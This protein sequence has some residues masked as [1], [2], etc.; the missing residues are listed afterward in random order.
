MKKMLPTKTKGFTLIEVAVAITIV[1][2]LIGSMAVPLSSRLA[3]QQ[4]TDTQANIDKAMEALMGFALTNQRLPCPDMDTTTPVGV[5]DGL[6]KLNAAGTACN[7]GT[8]TN[9]TAG[10][11]SWGDLPWRTIGLSAPNNADA[12][13]NRLRYAVFEPL[14]SM[15]AAPAIALTAV[16]VGI[17][18]QL[19][20]RCAK[21]PATPPVTTAPV[22]NAPGCTAN[23]VAD[24]FQLNPAA[25]F[26]VYSHGRNALGATSINDLGTI[27]MAL[28]TT[29]PD[30]IANAPELETTAAGRRQFVTRTRSGPNSNAGEYDDVLTYMSANTLAAKLFAAGLWH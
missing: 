5:R 27:G 6:E 10:V 20:I 19:D 9:T 29:V 12:W 11:V 17:A 22:A 23:P 21:P 26:V 8:L 16:N 14:A 4:Y 30:Q 15:P 13:D 7:A 2:L 24:P 3:E 25:S 18:V 28:T 1:A